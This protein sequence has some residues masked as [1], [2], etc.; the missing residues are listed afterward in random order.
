MFFCCTIDFS[1]VFRYVRVKQLKKKYVKGFGLP[2]TSHTYK[3]ICK[4][5]KSLSDNLTMA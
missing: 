2:Y 4:L 3:N 5:K 1:A